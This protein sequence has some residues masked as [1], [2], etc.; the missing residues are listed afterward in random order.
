MSGEK[1]FWEELD[2]EMELERMGWGD[3]ATGAALDLQETIAR[4]TQRV[5]ELLTGRTNLDLE[6]TN[7]I[8][9][10]TVHGNIKAALENKNSGQA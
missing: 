3:G 2:E 6:D 5:D 8:T 4:H 1:N 7:I 10:L 9:A